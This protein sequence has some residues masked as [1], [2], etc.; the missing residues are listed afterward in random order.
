MERWQVGRQIDGQGAM[1]QIEGKWKMLRLLGRV[2]GNE[3]GCA[4]PSHTL[5][6]V[7]HTHAM[8]GDLRAVVSMQEIRTK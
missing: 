3:G 7:F 5:D 2:L 8:V 1:G 4:I 6:D